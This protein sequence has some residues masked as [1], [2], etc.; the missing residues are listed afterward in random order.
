MVCQ[1]RWGQFR[2]CFR[3]A[4]VFCDRLNLARK[5]RFQFSKFL[6]KIKQLCF[7]QILYQYEVLY[8]DTAS[9]SYSVAKDVKLC[10]QVTAVVSRKLTNYLS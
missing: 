1:L 3:D 2:T 8:T 6:K 5:G 7:V 9:I 4:S 10:Y